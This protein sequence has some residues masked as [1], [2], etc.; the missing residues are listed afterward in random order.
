MRQLRHGKSYQELTN[1]ILL[2]SCVTNLYIQLNCHTYTL[3]IKLSATYVH[4]L[5]NKDLKSLD[6]H[7]KLLASFTELSS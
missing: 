3:T 1:K 4:T 6:E 5:A 7:P 2:V